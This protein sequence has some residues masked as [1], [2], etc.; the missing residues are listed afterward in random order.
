LA[1]WAPPSSGAIPP[2]L[3]VSG[4]CPSPA[5]N[6][7]E[8]SSLRALV[9]NKCVVWAFF[10]R[11]PKSE[12]KSVFSVRLRFPILRT[13]VFDFGFGFH[14]NRTELP[15]HMQTLKPS[16]WR[17]TS[18]GPNNDSSPPWRQPTQ[19]HRAPFI[20]IYC[21]CA[22]NPN[23]LW[24]P[25]PFPTCSTRRRLHCSSICSSAPPS[26]PPLTRPR[27]HARCHASTPPPRRRLPSH[28]PR[29]ASMHRPSRREE[30]RRS[31]RSAAGRTAVVGAGRICGRRS[32][33]TA[34]ATAAGGNRPVS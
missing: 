21:A 22:P 30:L 10:Q 20:L 18:L 16:I 4:R 3:C 25:I 31:G 29:D 28:S 12:P 24:F 9:T 7:T 11:R 19:A 6:G 32:R 27:L 1:A 5:S 23:P 26:R 15:E 34:G 33:G 13:S 14:P 17:L 8:R 2:P